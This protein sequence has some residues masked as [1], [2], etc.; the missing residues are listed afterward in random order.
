MSELIYTVI[1]LVQAD[2]AEAYYEYLG[3]GECPDCKAMPNNPRVSNDGLYGICTGI[4]F[5]YTLYTCTQ[6]EADVLMATE[7][8]VSIEEVA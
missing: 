7:N 4:D 5:Q 8:W 1:N 2:E 6:A 3:E